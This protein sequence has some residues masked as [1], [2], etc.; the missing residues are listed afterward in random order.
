MKL[1]TNRD[2]HQ[3]LHEA[4]SSEDCGTVCHLLDAGEKL[5]STDGIENCF[6]LITKF[7]NSGCLERVLTSQPS[8]I[9]CRGPQ[10][11][12]LLM[13]AKDMDFMRTLFKFKPD[14]NA[15]DDIGENA[16]IHLI[17]ECKCNYSKETAP[18]S[19]YLCM[20]ENVLFRG[21]NININAKNTIGKTAIEYFLELLDDLKSAVCSYV[22]PERIVELFE[23]LLNAGATLPPTD[24]LG[25]TSPMQFAR[26][27]YLPNFFTSIVDLLRQGADPKARDKNGHN[28]MYHVIL[29]YQE[30]NTDV[31]YN[32]TNPRRNRK[33]CEANAQQMSEQCV[34]LL[35]YGCELG[36]LDINFDELQSPYSRPRYGYVLLFKKKQFNMLSLMLRFVPFSR[37]FRELP[38][39][40]LTLTKNKTSLSELTCYFLDYLKWPID[41]ET[42][43]MVDATVTHLLASGVNVMDQGID[44]L[45]LEYVVNI[46]KK[47]VL[48]AYHIA[49]K[50]LISLLRFWT[51]PP[52]M[53]LLF[54]ICFSDFEH[55]SSESE[56][57]CVLTML[58]FL[59]R[60]GGRLPPGSLH[61]KRLKKYMEIRASTNTRDL[62]APSQLFNKLHE[63]IPSL[64]ELCRPAVR[65]TLSK[66]TTSGLDL[67]SLRVLCQGEWREIPREVQD[68]LNF[69]DQPEF[70]E[71]DLAEFKGNHVSR[72]PLRGYFD[73]D[74][75]PES[76]SFTAYRVDYFIDSD[77][78]DY[79]I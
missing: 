17:R 24:A 33:E 46:K 66:I 55:E 5:C 6:I 52:L 40:K 71:E 3:A 8:A 60:V 45:S 42:F 56:E 29:S 68:Y 32:V 37:F 31:I 30:N 22:T 65:A 21:I 15:C 72:Q 2:T 57:F 59:T 4:L 49:C 53:L 47:K 12:T 7:Y 41:N 70:C 63:E 51:Y 16:L 19:M 75:S 79:S 39:L 36:G 18:L 25:R 61:F 64:K 23:E 78:S 54:K 35:L 48:K 27:A 58:K 9:H 10:G 69:K 14:V 26:K 43:E 74:S 11:Q 62:K 28:L 1:E 76:E 13:Y 44:R 67:S 38:V 20:I 34:T 77:E 73:R 50:I